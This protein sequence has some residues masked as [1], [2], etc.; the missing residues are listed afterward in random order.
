LARIYFW[1]YWNLKLFVP[2]S[3][4]FVYHLIAFPSNWHLNFTLT[5][6]MH[7]LSLHY[8]DQYIHQQYL[9]SSNSFVYTLCKVHLFTMSIFTFHLRLH[10]FFVGLLG[11]LKAL[12]LPLTSNYGLSSLCSLLLSHSPSYIWFFIEKN[13]TSGPSYLC[14]S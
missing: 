3:R 14:C 5:L 1:I 4:L 8:K 2:N 13:S 9:E 11:S 12:L 7:P 10:C 6:E